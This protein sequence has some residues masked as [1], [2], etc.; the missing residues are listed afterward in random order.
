MLNECVDNLLHAGQTDDHTAT[1]PPSETRARDPEKSALGV[2][3]ATARIARV[4]CDVDCYQRKRLSSAAPSRGIAHRADR[5]QASVL[6]RPGR[7]TNNDKLPT[8]GSAP[9]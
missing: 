2:Y 6:E 9:F 1:L 3:K 5:R 7:V 4:K 8:R